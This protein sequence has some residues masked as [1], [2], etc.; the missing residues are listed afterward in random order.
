MDPHE[1]MSAVAVASVPRLGDWCTTYL[2][3][4]GTA[5]PWQ[6]TVHVEPE[7]L[8]HAR[9][10]RAGMK[11]DPEAELGIPR[12]LREGVTEFYPVV[13]DT[14]ASDE[15]LAPPVATIV[16]ELSIHSVIS[17]PL[18][19]RDR[20]VG[21]IQFVNSSTSRTFTEDDVLL[22]EAVASRVADALENLRLTAHQRMIATTLQTALLPGS[23]PS[24]AGVD[25]AVRYWATGEGTEVGGDF[26]DV[27][28]LDDGSWAVVI[29]DVC[30]TGPTAAATTGL[31]RHT[32]RASAWHGARH[33]AVLSELNHAL[34]RSGRTTFC[35]IAYCT[36]TATHGGFRFELAIGGHP[37]PILCR[38]GAG[39]EFVGEAGTL[40]GVLPDI[41]THPREV[42]LGPGDTVVL[43]T[44]GVNDVAPPHGISDDAML[45]MA[46]RAC[47]DAT[48]AEEI[49]DRLRAEI[50]T[51]LPLADRDDD[52]ALLVCRVADA[53]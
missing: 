24:I 26:Y 22:A 18:V 15:R 21:A 27:F 47:A 49:A 2:L 1:V 42:D 33:G 6:D 32:V 40:I 39:A 44:D 51:V 25:V 29:G 37:L 31:A 48:S 17:V 46:G 8:D 30:G 5:A 16:R 50:D 12:V 10:L 43:Y 20:V 14:A 36:L 52:I 53:G 3:S 28:E 45:A 41:R 38:A 23:L 4:E 34:L 13:D 7:L 11:W 35:T 19:K 9:E